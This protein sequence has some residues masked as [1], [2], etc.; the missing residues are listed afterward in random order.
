LQVPEVL[1]QK[2][3]EEAQ[4]A[5][6]ATSHRIKQGSGVS[7]MLASFELHAEKVSMQLHCSGWGMC[8]PCSYMMNGDADDPDLPA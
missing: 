6:L 4:R 1:D 8:D 3:P 2:I 5:G 7:S